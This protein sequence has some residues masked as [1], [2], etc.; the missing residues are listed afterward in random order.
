[1]TTQALLVQL[2]SDVVVGDGAEQAAVNAGLL[3]QLDGGAGELFAK[4]WAAASFSAA[5]FSSSARGFE[6]GLGGS[7]GAAGAAR[8]DQ[9]VAG[10]AVLDL[11]DFAQVAQVHNLVEQN[12]LHGC[13]P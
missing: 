5:A 9:E 4:A 6:L 11:D 12:D 8:G 10:V 13:A 7:G 1:L 3:G 2:F